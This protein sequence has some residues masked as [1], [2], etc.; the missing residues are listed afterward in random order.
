M[1][2]PKH[3]RLSLGALAVAFMVS[4]ATAANYT[5]DWLNMAPTPFGSPLPNNSFFNLPNVGNV[6]VTYSYPTYF[7]QARSQNVDL[8][9]GN[10][11]SGGDNYAWTSH[12][13]LSTVFPVGNDPL[14]PVPW[15][16][17]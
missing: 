2:F 9:N 11:T 6:L 5:I 7:T 1:L 14:V 15:R 12:E 4:T 3:T 8:Q 13:L 10:V 16:I 17:T